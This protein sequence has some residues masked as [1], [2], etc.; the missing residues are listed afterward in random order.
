MMKEETKGRLIS[1]GRMLFHGGIPL[2]IV[3][4]ILDYWGEGLSNDASMEWNIFVT[5][6]CMGAACLVMLIALFLQFVEWK[7]KYKKP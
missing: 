6:S 1:L 2:I 4:I 3:I 5:V 7:Y